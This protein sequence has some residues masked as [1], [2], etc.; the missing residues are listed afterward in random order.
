MES[1]KAKEHDDSS[2]FE[3]VAQVV[4]ELY[5]YR[6]EVL[7]VLTKA[8]GSSMEHM[9]DRLVDQMDEHNAFICEAMCKAYHV[10]MV[11]QSVVHWMSHSQIDMFIFMVTHMDDEEEA[12]RFAEKGVNICWQAGR[13]CQTVGRP[14]VLTE[15]REKKHRSSAFGQKVQKRSTGLSL[16]AGDLKKEPEVR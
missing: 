16:F 15:G 12:L 1:G 5:T 8:Q 3:A 4:H 11:E 13:T 2:D 6:D 10:P 14:H 7:L 9:P